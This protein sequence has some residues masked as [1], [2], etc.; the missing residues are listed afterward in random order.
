[1]MNCAALKLALT[2]NG[3]GGQR[4]V[5]NH[6]FP[7]V[8]HVRESVRL[9]LYCKTVHGLEDCVY[10]RILHNRHQQYSDHCDELK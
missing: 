10:S 8:L 6:R 1:M 4:H 7:D 9:D 3:G 2:F 5:C